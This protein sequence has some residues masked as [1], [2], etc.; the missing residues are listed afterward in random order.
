MIAATPTPRPSDLTLEVFG[1]SGSFTLR[2]NLSALTVRQG[3]IREVSTREKQPVPGRS[4]WNLAGSGD[5]APLQTL[6]GGVQRVVYTAQDEHFG[7]FRLSVLLGSDIPSP[8][9]LIDD[10]YSSLYSVVV[11]PRTL[12]FS[13][14]MKDWPFTASS[15]VLQYE[16]FLVAPVA[17]TSLQEET[18]GVLVSDLG[19]SRV[20]EMA[21]GNATFPTTGLVDGQIV[22]NIQVEVERTNQ[23]THRVRITLPRGGTVMAYDPD[24]SL[25]TEPETTSD[26][27][28]PTS[29]VLHWE[30]PSTSTVAIV[31][32]VVGVVLVVVVVML[33]CGYRQ[34]RQQETSYRGSVDGALG[35]GS[36]DDSD[37]GLP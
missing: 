13:I 32:G 33:I 30:A 9:E 29:V 4:S 22:R 18:E 26:V 20:V 21:T 24:V 16:L 7:S 15:N 28:E 34:S 3:K 10:V 1:K 14:E 37:G 35:G 19:G 17:D 23:T 11:L 12:K 27:G 25:K 2:N 5:F 8:V 6:A 36:I 31:V